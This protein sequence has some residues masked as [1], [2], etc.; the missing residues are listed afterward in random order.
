[1]RGAAQAWEDW[2]SERLES[3]GY[4]QV[5][6]AASTFWNRDTGGRVVVHGDDL[7]ILGHAPE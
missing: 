7:P 5:V 3:A 4:K 2:Y 6:S 1:M